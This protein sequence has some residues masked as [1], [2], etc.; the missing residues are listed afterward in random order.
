MRPIPRERRRPSRSPSFPQ[1]L[2]LLEKPQ[3]GLRMS[4]GSH[5]GVVAASFMSSWPG[6]GLGWGREVARAQNLRRHLLSGHAMQAPCLSTSLNF[7]PRPLAPLPLVQALLPALPSCSGFPICQPP[8]Q[9]H[10]TDAEQL[11]WSLAGLL[12]MW[13]DTSLLWPRITKQLARPTCTAASSLWRVR[14]EC[15]RPGPRMWT[16]GWS[17]SWILARPKASSW[18]EMWFLCW[19]GG[20]LALASPIPCT[21][22]LCLDGFQSPCPIPFPQPSH[23][24]SNA[25]STRLGLSCGWDTREED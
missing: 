8:H 17:W 1:G 12:T 21:W 20:I 4:L 18:R 25:C 6:L 10:R 9:V 15:R 19:P 24:A 2:R 14:T 16:S 23:S 13:P 22:R 5:S 3:Q 11:G 7:A